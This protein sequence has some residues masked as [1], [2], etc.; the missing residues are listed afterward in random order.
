MHPR[1]N[2][3]FRIPSLIIIIKK[4]IIIFCIGKADDDLVGE[5][6]SSSDKWQ[7]NIYN[8][9]CNFFGTKHC[10]INLLHAIRIVLYSECCCIPLQLPWL[11]HQPKELVHR[12][13][14]CL[15]IISCFMW[16]EMLVGEVKKGREVQWLDWGTEG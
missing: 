1:A 11:V 9:L 4:I 3:E 12:E 10:E 13:S 6:R 5:E 14:Y 8:K 2:W 15:I 7:M 16:K